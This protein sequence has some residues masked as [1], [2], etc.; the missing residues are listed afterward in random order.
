MEEEN[1]QYEEHTTSEEHLSRPLW[2]RISNKLS[3]TL[4]VS[5]IPFML[6]LAGL[7]ALYITNNNKAVDLVKE[8]ES[9]NKELK[10]VKWA[11]SDIQSRLIRATSETELRKKSDH[12][13]LHPLEK[14]VFEIKNTVTINEKKK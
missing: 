3:I 10:E 14:P 9:K 2:E 6:F 8:L 11:F 7:S 12:L 5:N 4:L 1:K 13:G